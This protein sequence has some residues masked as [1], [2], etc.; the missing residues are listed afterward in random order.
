MEASPDHHAREE[1]KNNRHSLGEEAYGTGARVSF[2]CL[3]FLGSECPLSLLVGANPQ[4][5]GA[6]MGGPSRLMD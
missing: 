6:G 1:V 5:G 3:C 4:C 2:A